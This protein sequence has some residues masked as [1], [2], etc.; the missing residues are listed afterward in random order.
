MSLKNWRRQPPG[1]RGARRGT[2]ALEFALAG[3]LMCLILGG[4]F[5]CGWAYFCKAALANAV[6]SGM[7]YATLQQLGA[8]GSTATLDQVLAV[9]QYSMLGPGGTTSANLSVTA[10]NSGNG[11]AEWPTGYS[12]PG[13]YCLASSPGLKQFSASSQGSVCSDGSAAGY[14]IGIAATYTNIS[15]MG[16][17]MPLANIPVSESVLARTH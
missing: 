12:A 8:T 1:R 11:P 13:W 15:L 17:F 3:P 9:V 6:A 16:N 7:E 2:A 14:Y 10:T 4:I 5:D